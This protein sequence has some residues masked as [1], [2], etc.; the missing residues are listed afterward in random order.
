MTKGEVLQLGE[1]PDWFLQNL[2]S[3]VPSIKEPG[4][5]KL[6]WKCPIHGEYTQSIVA[7]LSGAGCRHCAPKVSHSVRRMKNIQPQW[8]FDDMREDFVEKVKNQEVSMGAK[9]PFLCKEHGYY[10]QVGNHHLAGHNGCPICRKRLRAEASKKAKR[11][12]NPV[13]QWVFDEMAEDSIFKFKNGGSANDEYEFICPKHGVYKQVFYAHVS[14]LSGDRKC[15]CPTCGAQT[16]LFGSK[17]EAKL[18]QDLLNCGINSYKAK[19]IIKS[20]IT[21]FPMELDLYIPD[22]KVAIE[23]NGIYYHSI[24]VMK[25]SDLY[26]AVGGKENYHRMKTDLCKEKGIQLIHLWEDDLLDSY[27]VC[28]NLVKSKC[29]LRGWT[30]LNA[31]KVYARKCII[32][33]VSTEE[34]R[35]FYQN[36]HI[37]GW[38]HGIPIGLFHEGTL[39]ALMSMRRSCD[40]TQDKGSWELNR[41]ATSCCVVG[42]FEK[43]LHYFISEYKIIRIISYADLAVSD[44]NL[45]EKHGFTL[46][47][48]VPVDYK[49]VYRRKRYHKFNFRKQRFK[50]DPDL[51]YQEGLSEVELSRLNGINRIYDCGKLKYVLD[52]N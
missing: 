37:Q 36:N 11:E 4:T 18:K 40:N 46:V 34:A 20:P 17:L 35:G 45:Y 26:D 16:S 32:K 49:Y 8:F 28:L 50:E 15:G 9:M 13:P 33:Q 30:D 19:G 52:V 42:G 43:L 2:V 38:G 48:E 6:I 31:T 14:M 51:E 1:W 5:T 7:H 44:G 27:D 24:E 47:D 21:G 10:W 25:Q 3:D 29:R 23:V 12:N 41:F 39:V 22:Y